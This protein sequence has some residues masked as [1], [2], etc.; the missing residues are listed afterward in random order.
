[1]EKESSDVYMDVVCQFMR[2]SCMYT[3]VQEGLRMVQWLLWCGNPTTFLG[4]WVIVVGVSEI[5]P[6]AKLDHIQSKVQFTGNSSET[7]ILNV[8]YMIH[9]MVYRC[10]MASGVG[11]IARRRP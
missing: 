2:Y 6:Y 1:M 4:K 7:I 3:S 11:I 5:D 10:T 9:Q 8:Q